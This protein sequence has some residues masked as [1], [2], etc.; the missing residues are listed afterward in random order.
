MMPDRA[1]PLVPM[2]AATLAALLLIG[3]TLAVPA[4]GLVAIP[5]EPG[6][7]TLLDGPIFQAVVADLDRDEVREIVALVRPSEGLMAAVA[8]RET[9][10]GWSAVGDPTPVQFPGAGPLQWSGTPARLI[11]REAA[12]HDVV[13]IVRQPRS[14]EL[15]LEAECCLVVDDLLLGSDGLR[16]APRTGRLDAMDALH[17]VDLD[18]DGTDELVATRSVPPLGDI[19]FPTAVAILRWNGSAFDATMSELPVGSGDTPFV[20]GDSDG[21]PG[22][23]MA[24]IATLGQ[25][26]LYRLRLGAND[27]FLVDEAEVV[28]RDATAVPVDG[29]RGL[30]I[31][32]T[33]GQ[34]SIHTWPAGAAPG[35][36]V[37]VAAMD[38]A[39]LLGPV[40]VDGTDRLAV[41]QFLGADQLH[42]LRLPDLSPDPR[43]AIAG[44][45]AAQAFASGGPVRPYVGELPGGTPTG[46]R[47]AVFSGQLVTS[48]ELDPGIVP[49]PL[50]AGAQPL[51]LAGADRQTLAVLHGMR[52]LPW[53]G[54]LGGR[55]DPPATVPGSAITV[56]PLPLATREEAG[57][58]RLE[59]TVSGTVVHGVDGELAIGAAG[60]RA[61]IEAPAGSRVY[62]AASDPS[63]VASTAVVPA[64]G[65]LEVPLVPPAVPMDDPR[66]RFSVAVTTPAGHSAL[67]TWDAQVITEPPEL[68]VTVTTPIGSGDV[69]VRGST[70]P[71]VTLTVA[72]QPVTVDSTGRFET[73]VPVP[74]WPTSIEVAGIDPFGNSTEQAV[75]AVGWFDY[76]GLPW[77]L[78]AAGILGVAAGRLFLRVPRSRERPRVADGDGALEELEPD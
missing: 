11:V 61:V 28:A 76:R 57:D 16:L 47:A 27:S 60:F 19:S 44:S 2:L 29:D 40:R 75:S 65:R 78:I 43:G 14:S 66:H 45:R 42:L 41:R 3:P 23:E 51:G 67:A 37:G 53:L 77:G 63:V 18:G 70:E 12:G 46:D 74:P 24:I 71:Y 25:P 36:A 69:T 49:F 20:L 52:T 35:A 15:D 4:S 62:V 5:D 50:L 9:S 17:V 56:A 26:E 30:A 22:E 54:P 58:G 38:A 7:A 33:S 59:P 21:V 39:T 8:F 72:G 34:L 64:D 73:R 48:A 31:L 55:L 68:D 32:A 10:D 6:T 1:Y 13:S